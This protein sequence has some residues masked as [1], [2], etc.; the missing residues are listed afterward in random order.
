MN[1]FLLLYMRYKTGFIL[2]TIPVDYHLK[3]CN[4][5][6]C[7][8]IVNVKKE[9]ILSKCCYYITGKTIIK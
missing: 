6:R 2:V 9:M 5:K 7:N 1:Y 3:Q 4:I 8:L